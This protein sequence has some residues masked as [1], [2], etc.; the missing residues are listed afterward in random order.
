MEQYDVVILGAGH[1]ALVLQAYLAGSG[2]KTIALERRSKPGGGLD[3]IEHPSGSGFL[4]NPHSFFHRGITSMPWFDDLQLD[5]NGA[6]YI[7]PDC[8]VSVINGENQAIKWHREFDVTLQT[9]RQFSRADADK[10]EYW[11]ETFRPVLT[12]ILIPESRRPP[13]PAEERS[14]WLNQSAA[15]RLLL[16]VSA[17][18]PLDF[19]NREFEHPF[20][21]GALLFFNGLREVDLRLSGFGYHIPALL[22]SDTLAQMCIGGSEQLAHSLCN[23]IRK[24]GGEIR[25]NCEIEEIQVFGGRA[26]GVKLATG[27]LIQAERAVVSSLN[28]QQTMLGLLASEHVPSSWR[29]KAEQFRYNLIAPLFGVYL[30]LNSPVSYLAAEHDSE[31]NE[32]LMTVLG[33]DEVSQFSEIVKHHEQGTIPPT[34]MWGSCPT[35][36]DPSQSPDGQHVAF[37]WEKLPMDV[38]G[39]REHWHDLAAEHANSMI[40]LWS[41]HAPCLK[42]S[43]VDIRIQSPLEIPRTL[44]NMIDGDLLVGSFDH[45]QIGFNR[46]FAGAG[47][48]R[49]CV[50]A[51]YM[52]GASC[53]PGGNITGL[54]G[55]NCQQVLTADLGVVD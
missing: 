1:N 30:N 35:Q 51:L 21:K 45:G 12:E 28:P 13:V 39:D 43:I 49:T 8:N 55:Y 15:G 14:R 22:A 47:H 23:V 46:P 10:L 37:M 25:C 36:F 18:S 50:E 5:A 42:D 34:V 33:L 3:T 6:Q 11:H 32:S 9:V 54:P 24:A 20:V 52:C 16:E 40:D 19:V 48:Y 38:H 4:H 53:F 2:L 31:V 41:K 44:H 27:E 26:T 29:E 17:L 7:E